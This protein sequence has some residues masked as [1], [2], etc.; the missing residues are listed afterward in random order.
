MENSLLRTYAL[1]RLVKAKLQIL[2][3]KKKKRILTSFCFDD[4]FKCLDG[5]E[6]CWVISEML[7]WWGALICWGYCSMHF[8]LSLHDNFFFS[9]ASLQDIYFLYI[10]LITLVFLFLCFFFL[11]LH[12]VFSI[13][14]MYILLKVIRFMCISFPIPCGRLHISWNPVM[15]VLLSACQPASQKIILPSKS[16]QNFLSAWS[17]LLQVQLNISLLPQQRKKSAT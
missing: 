14:F 11:D 6:R 7:T 2:G 16:P 15:I 4:H 8:L 9:W 5:W 3:A 13:T 17:K 1:P 12:N 10:D